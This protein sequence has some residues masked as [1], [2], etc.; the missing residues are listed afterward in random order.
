[1]G[2]TPL[3]RTA[4]VA[5]ALANP[6][7]LRIVAMLADGELCACQITEVLK[8]APSTVS[9]HLLKLRQ[10][11]ITAERKEGRWVHVRLAA[12][13]DLAAWVEGSLAALAGDRRITAD[14][15]L[16]EKLRQVGAADL[17]RLGYEKALAARGKDG[18]AHDAPGT[19]STS[20]QS[21]EVT[22]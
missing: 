18:P 4:T 12:D 14:R 13:P 21:S 6:A 10:A 8:L 3:D 15:R 7:R 1:M 9:A 5:R 22:S 2:T 16:V 19:R 11:G 20:H 17:C